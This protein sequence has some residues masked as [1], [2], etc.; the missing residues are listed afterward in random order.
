MIPDEIADAVRERQQQEAAETAKL[1]AKG[2]PVARLNT[3]IDGGMN[4]VFAAKLPDGNTGLSE[5]GDS[6]SLRDAGA[7]ARARHHPVHRQ[8]AETN[9]AQ[10]EEPAGGGCDRPPSTPRRR[11]GVASAAPATQ[12]V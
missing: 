10:P 3:G 4:K 1:I 8:S 7:V 12:Q 5:G 2:T 11:P 6:Q 9:L